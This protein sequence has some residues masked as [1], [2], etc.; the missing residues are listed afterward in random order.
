MLDLGLY[1]KELRNVHNLN[2]AS[3][4]YLSLLLMPFLSVVSWFSLMCDVIEHK[5]TSLGQ[6]SPYNS[7]HESVVLPPC[8]WVCI[9]GIARVAEYVFIYCMPKSSSPFSFFNKMPT[10]HD[11][12]IMYVLT[13]RLFVY[14]RYYLTFRGSCFHFLSLF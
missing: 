7:P 4:N 11:L 5:Y 8:F 2:L 9:H 12:H 13:I 1:L 3:T 10:F 6:S 14:S